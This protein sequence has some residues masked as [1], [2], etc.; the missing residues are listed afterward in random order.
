MV[1]SPHS[2]DPVDA[3]GLDAPP[4]AWS[5]ETTT[6]LLFVVLLFL[7]VHKDG[8]IDYV[9]FCIFFLSLNIMF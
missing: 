8:I 2:G 9:V 7:E 4:H 6:P 5:Q 1:D 3:C